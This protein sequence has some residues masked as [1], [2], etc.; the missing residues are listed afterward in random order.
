MSD[1]SLKN[2]LIKKLSKCKN[3]KECNKNC[4]KFIIEGYGKNNL[5]LVKNFSTG[6]I[7][8]LEYEEILE[9]KWRWK[10]IL[11]DFNLV[12]NIF[13]DNRVKVENWKIPFNPF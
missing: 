4:I 10:T 11:S 7:S 3:Q 2:K 6:N 12:K 1:N 8:I 9:E 5:V 13:Y